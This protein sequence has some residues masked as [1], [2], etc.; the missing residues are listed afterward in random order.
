MQS[1]TRVVN[2]FF[3]ASPIRS[4]IDKK[5]AKFILYKIFEVNQNGQSEIHPR[6][7]FNIKMKK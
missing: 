3:M 4:N 2:G 6:A 7:E 5:V 1:L